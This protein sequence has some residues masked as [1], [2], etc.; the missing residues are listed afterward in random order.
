MYYFVFQKFVMIFEESKAE[1]F[2]LFK[3]DDELFIGIKKH[4]FLTISAIF[5]KII[6]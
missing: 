2:G 4:S 3:E 1:N 6:S 5:C